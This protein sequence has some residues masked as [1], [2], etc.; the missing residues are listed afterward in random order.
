M[1]IHTLQSSDTNALAGETKN[2][3]LWIILTT[4]L[5]LFVFCVKYFL[6][7]LLQLFLAVHPQPL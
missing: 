2:Y 5:W 3:V 6:T 7:F 1:F 4:I